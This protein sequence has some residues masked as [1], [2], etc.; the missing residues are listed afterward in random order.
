MKFLVIILLLNFLFSCGKETRTKII[1]QGQEVQNGGYGVVIENEDE[2]EKVVSLDL[3][4]RGS[5]LDPLIHKSIQYLQTAEIE[6]IYAYF[7]PIF[8][9]DV[10]DIVLGKLSDL[11]YFSEKIEKTYLVSHLI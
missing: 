5:H 1:K 11:R 2:K 6:T 4:L 10:I 8:S 3:Y 9:H 7:G